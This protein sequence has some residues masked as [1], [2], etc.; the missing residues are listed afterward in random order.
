MCD[1]VSELPERCLVGTDSSCEGSARGVVVKIVPVEAWKGIEGGKK[2]GWGMEGEV[3]RGREGR[4]EESG[5][6]MEWDQN[7]HNTMQEYRLD[8]YGYVL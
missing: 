6:Y 4:R 1:I 3:G 7:L 8:L 5:G 2:R